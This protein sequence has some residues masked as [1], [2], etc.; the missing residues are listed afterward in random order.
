M[1]S[2]III[3]IYIIKRK[4]IILLYNKTANYVLSNIII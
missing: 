2:F 3:V 4:Y 1:F